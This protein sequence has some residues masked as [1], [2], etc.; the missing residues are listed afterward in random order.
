MGR[1]EIAA[2]S[3]MAELGALAQQRAFLYYSVSWVESGFIFSLL[4]DLTLL[5]IAF[6]I[7]REVDIC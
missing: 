7:L 3:K 2:K 1:R 6:W 5:Y 4:I